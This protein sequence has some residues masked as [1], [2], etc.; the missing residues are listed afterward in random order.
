MGHAPSPFKFVSAITPDSLWEEK[1][2]VQITNGDGNRWSAGLPQLEAELSERSVHRLMSSVIRLIVD[3][4]LGLV[5]LPEDY[6]TAVEE[7]QRELIEASFL[8]WFVSEVMAS[9]TCVGEVSRQLR[10]TVRTLVTQSDAE[11]S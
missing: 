1:I 2:I 9:D 10:K 7:G 11:A 3:F 4:Y 6:V 5:A 8:P